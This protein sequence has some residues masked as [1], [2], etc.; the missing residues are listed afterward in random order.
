MRRAQRWLLCLLAGVALWLVALNYLPGDSELRPSLQAVRGP[1]NLSTP[2]FSLCV[3]SHGVLQLPLYILIVFGCYS[4]ATIAW[5]LMTF[6][7]CPDEA[8]SLQKVPQY[9]QKHRC[10]Q[11]YFQTEIRR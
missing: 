1:N 10:I 4:L 8:I 6:P 11:N 9:I 7:E 2:P 3:D 5:N